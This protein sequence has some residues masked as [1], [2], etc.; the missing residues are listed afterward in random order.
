M[1]TK[2]AVSCVLPHAARDQVHVNASEINGRVM[3]AAPAG[4]TVVS[5][6]DGLERLRAPWMVVKVKDVTN[7]VL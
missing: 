4:C 5:G 1:I 7:V 6:R 2:V 3:L